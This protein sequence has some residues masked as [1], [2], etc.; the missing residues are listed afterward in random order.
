[1][2]KNWPHM[3]KKEVILRDGWSTDSNYKNL[4]QHDQE[5]LEILE[6]LD[7]EGARGLL[8]NG[9]GNGAFSIQAARSHTSLQV[10][11]YDALQSAISEARSRASEA[12][13]R[14]VTL[15]VGWAD[16]LP[17]ASSSVDRALFRNVLHHIPEPSTAFSEIARCLRSDGKLILQ[18]P[19]NKW[20]ESFSSFLTD[21]HLL[22]DDSHP[23]S[24]H[25]VDDIC[26]DLELCGFSVVALSSSNYDFPFVTR[27]MKNFIIQNGFWDRLQPTEVAEEKWSVSLQWLRMVAKKTNAEQDVEG[28][29]P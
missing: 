16:D 26:G 13:V 24:Y 19:Y 28:Q 29:A 23:R 2:K 27:E 18:T 11:G 15:D 5:V 6:L 22:M 9:C 8:D 4:Y 14:N 21:F 7:L 1:M 17:L 25:T 3:S 12:G 20:E 10:Y